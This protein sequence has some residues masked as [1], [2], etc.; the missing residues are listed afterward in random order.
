[1]LGTMTNG[2]PPQISVAVGIVIGLVAS[3]IQSAGLTMQRKS[4]LMNESLPEEERKPE[5][6]RP[7]WLF[8][9]TIFFTS[10][11]FGSVFQIASLPVV[12]L[13]PLGAVSLL[14]NALFA[15]L[16][17]GDVFS[18]YM[19]FGTF[20]I[21]GGAVLIAIFGIVPEPT[22]SLEDLL[23]LFGRKTFIVYFSLLGTFLAIILIITHIA[24]SRIPVEFIYDSPATEPV[25]LPRE[26]DNGLEVPLT[27]A[28]GR[29]SERTPL[30][31][32]DNKSQTSLA[33]MS[34]QQKYIARTKISI[35][36]GLVYYDQLA[37]LSTFK[38]CMVLLGIT[39]LLL[40]VWAVSMQPGGNTRV[41]VGTWQ[42]GT[43]V[44]TA[45]ITGTESVVVTAGQ[46]VDPNNDPSTGTT[47]HS[48]TI[49]TR[50][51]TTSGGG[52]PTLILSTSPDSLAE[53][54]RDESISP[55][56]RDRHPSGGV[57]PP[58][59]PFPSLIRSPT[60]ASRGGYG[61]LGHGPHSPGSPDAQMHGHGHRPTR[62]KWST[63]F[64]SQQGTT[65]G[66]SI[67]LSATSPGFALVPSERRRVSSA[68]YSVDSVGIGRRTVSESDVLRRGSLGSP[69]GAEDAV[70]GLGSATSGRYG[71]TQ[72]TEQP[73][74]SDKKG[75]KWLRGV[76]KL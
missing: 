31:M 14:W 12:I 45:E 40:G 9:F 22:H 34:N 30:L 2:D 28:A 46:E 23:R 16:L 21:A 75:W 51:T 62:R 10:N 61:D 58:A 19:I 4:H 33:A 37:L 24:E 67:G 26:S 63:F 44:L 73:S 60:R 53:R 38:L 42:E 7:L 6:R 17:L 36:N 74:G 70:A 71:A 41:E 32:I 8:G 29:A 48:R 43:E 5:R 54:E 20:L 68:T 69:R 49:Y 35:F 59:T 65:A 57:S 64:D 66:L 27:T 1:M 72:T 55:L 13:A 3:L 25:P 50:A 76:F 18:R 39:V 47:R 56:P 15:K 11:V 52:V